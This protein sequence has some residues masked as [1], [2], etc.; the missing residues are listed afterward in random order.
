MQKSLTLH[1]SLFTLF[2]KKKKKRSLCHQI[3]TEMGV[4][5]FFPIPKQVSHFFSA[6]NVVLTNRHAVFMW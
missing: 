3:F 5:L 1:N 4:Y 2:T 6:R